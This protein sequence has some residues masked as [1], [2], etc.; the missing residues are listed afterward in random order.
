VKAVQFHEYGGI[1][2]LRV[3]EVERPVPGPGQVLV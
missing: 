3:E 2:V 1:V